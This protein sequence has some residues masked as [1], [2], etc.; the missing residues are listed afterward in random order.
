[1]DGNEENTE[2]NEEAEEQMYLRKAYEC[3]DN[4]SNP[5]DK[6][7]CRL[8][9]KLARIRCDMNTMRQAYA[10]MVSSHPS[11]TQAKPVNSADPY[12]QNYA[13]YQIHHEMLSVSAPR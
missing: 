4:S 11:G 2:Q 13:H 5:K 12:F 3:S 10:R 8:H 6:I 9:E 1:M 7:I